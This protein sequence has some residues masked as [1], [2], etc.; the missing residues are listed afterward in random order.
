MV[1]NASSPGNVT[2]SIHLPAWQKTCFSGN[3]GR[4]PYL[5]LMVFYDSPGRLKAIPRAGMDC[6]SDQPADVNQGGQTLRN[7]ISSAASST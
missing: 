5:H 4:E 2:V 3:G 6:R 7:Q 1:L